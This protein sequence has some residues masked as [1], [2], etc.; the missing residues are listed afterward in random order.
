MHPSSSAQE[1]K[2]SIW[3][4][5]VH[6]DPPT[7]T[8]LGTTPNCT[9]PLLHPQEAQGSDGGLVYSWA[10]HRVDLYLASLQ[11]HLPRITEGGSLAS[12]LEHCMYCGASLARVGLDFRS[13]LPPIF[14]AC[15]LQLFSKVCRIGVERV[16]G[17]WGGSWGGGGGGGI[18]VL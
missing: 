16:G 8:P 7:P 13:L 18:S 11:R 9:P 1:E 14:E 6:L 15:I 10:D 5:G 4:S 12:V 2:G 17:G 3:A